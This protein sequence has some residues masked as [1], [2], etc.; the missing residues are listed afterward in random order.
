MLGKK[1]RVF[2]P[3]DES[4]YTGTVQEYDASTL[5]H[6]LCYSDGDT[7][8]VKI[9][10]NTPGA[11]A[12]RVGSGSDAPSGGTDSLGAVDPANADPIKGDGPGAAELGGS[13]D[14]LR[15]ADNMQRLDMAHAGGFPGGQFPPHPFGA[16]QHS[17][18]PYGYGPPYGGGMY[19][20]QFG[21]PPSPPR[22]RLAQEEAHSP[23]N[24]V[25]GAKRKAGPKA[26][27]KEE[28]ALLLQI[29][30]NMRVPM[31]WSIVAQSLPER[32]GKQCRERYVNH[33]NPRLKSSDWNPV[34]D[35]TI[36]HLY[37]S[38]GSHWAKMSKVV[39]GR[40]DNGIKNRFHNLRRQYEREDE[41]RL[42]LSSVADFPDD[43]RLD[44]L[45]TFPKN[46]K[47]KSNSELWDITAGIGVLAAQSILGNIGSS[48][49]SNYF[50]SFREAKDGESCVRC[51]LFL[52]SVHTGNSVCVKT[53]W[54][55]SCTRIP[56]HLSGNLLREC[57]NLRRAEDKDK[58]EII[59]A[60]E[61]FFLK[62]EG[63]M[64]V[65]PG[66]KSTEK[67]EDALVKSEKKIE[68][69]ASE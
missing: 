12:V 63:D 27:S 40:T 69:A 21:G 37:G 24:D 7:E 17:M 46:L 62:E 52:P 20:P 11:V 14:R 19:P 26:W 47:N 66:E 34:E 53:G 6:L 5:E 64:I 56:P 68:K 59:E 36:F 2:W 16:M 4:W 22:V 45:R 31:K 65:V 57:L 8:W 54:C 60:F 33:L 30:Q 55:Q 67:D 58:R 29:V 32:T 44:R 42:R 9:G 50:G 25:G 23:G 41:H 18:G 15:Q 1:V 38:M 10:E 51:G 39:P 13:P 49:T 43:I 61:E 28:D 48:R 3:V 35:T